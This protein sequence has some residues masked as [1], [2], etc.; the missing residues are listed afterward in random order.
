MFDSK[1]KS[2][3]L[4][5]LAAFLLLVF[6]PAC[7]NGFGIDP[8]P[9]SVDCP[10]E[11]EA[12]GLC[13]AIEWK[14]ALQTEEAV[15]GSLRVFSKDSLKSDRVNRQLDGLELRVSTVMQCCGKHL[16]ARAGIG[17]NGLFNI[18]DVKFDSPGNWAVI[19]ELVDSNGDVRA[20]TQRV[21]LVQ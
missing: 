1:I 6:I 15:Q 19:F 14:T 10:M 5:G 7:G 11:F 20:K 17:E 8:V 18:Y 3:L 16:A 13:G 9:I 21:Y 4:R 2:G 12:M